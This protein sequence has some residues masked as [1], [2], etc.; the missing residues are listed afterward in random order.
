MAKLVMKNTFLTFAV[1]E[2]KL[3]VPRR[4]A[5]SEPSRRDGGNVE[6]GMDLQ[7]QRLEQCFKSQGQAQTDSDASELSMLPLASQMVL[8]SLASAGMMAL[9]QRL[10][11]AGV[12][13][14]DCNFARVASNASISTM[15]PEDSDHGS[16]SLVPSSSEFCRSRQTFRWA[17]VS[18]PEARVPLRN[19][20]EARKA[21]VSKKHAV[22]TWTNPHVSKMFADNTQ[23]APGQ[24][25]GAGADWLASWN[26][27][28]VVAQLWSTANAGSW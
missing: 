9:Q 14:S 12:E 21:A 2:A 4:R 23:L 8:S 3:D 22:S 20:R 19:R 10:L 25:W 28:A 13:A 24:G 17:D 5:H 16:E 1:D 11:E 6:A 7:L 18:C 26:Q 15:V 27:Q